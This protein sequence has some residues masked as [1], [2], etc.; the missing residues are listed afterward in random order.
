MA[1]GAPETGAAGM[2]TV[3]E[4]GVEVVRLWVARPGEPEKYPDGRKTVEVVVSNQVE[5]VSRDLAAPVLKFW[6]EVD[7]ADVPG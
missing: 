2:V 3:T 4:D 1:A 5:V 7:D 6:W